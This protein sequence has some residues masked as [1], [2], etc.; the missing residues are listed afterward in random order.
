MILVIYLSFPSVPGG[1][2]HLTEVVSIDQ[3][4]ARYIGPGIQM[5]G[6]LVAQVLPIMFSCMSE[7]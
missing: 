2:G 1:H 4:K 3:L 6:S 7:L 5:T